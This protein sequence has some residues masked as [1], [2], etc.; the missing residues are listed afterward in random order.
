MTDYLE[1]ND[2]QT[3]PGLR[4]VLTAG[5]PG[6]WSES[7]KALFRH[8]G[9]SYLPVRQDGGRDNPELVAWTRHRN[10]PI[11]LYNDEA[12]RVRWLELL[13]LA[14][15][16]GQVEVNSP[17]LYP[18]DRTERMLMVGLINEIAGENGFAWNARQLM[19]NATYQATGDKA[20][21]NP[22]L[23]DY[24]FDPGKVESVKTAL[25]D[26]LAF[27]ARHLDAQP[28]RYLIGDRFSA[29]DLYWAYFSNLLS[30]Q[31][32]TI[33]PM[34]GFLRKSYE[35]PATLIAPFDE[36]LVAQRD[37][38]FEQHLETPLTF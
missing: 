8:H 21:K 28:G 6:P 16:L 12:P 3:Q 29:A 37:W 27:L 17:S 30:P 26:F 32:E 15:R 4:L 22:M 10:A 2:A 14:E 1:V 31:D 24:Q 9:V 33:N 11:A 23:R 36:S 13:D 38:I 35:L 19:L 34:P 18:V 20:Y 7:A 5:V 25:N